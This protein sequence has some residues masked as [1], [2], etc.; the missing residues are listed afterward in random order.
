MCYICRSNFILNTDSM[1]IDFNNMDA[2]LVMDFKGGNGALEMKSFVDE[3]NR[4]MLSRLKPGASIGYHMHE[5]NSEVIYFF[6][7]KG[8]FDYDGTREEISAGTV[9]YCP[10][11]HS[12]AMFNDGDEDLVYFAIVPEHH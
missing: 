5:N 9:H 12:H 3:K 7:G 8:H 4:V 6:S 11:G 1:N 2:Q 10:M